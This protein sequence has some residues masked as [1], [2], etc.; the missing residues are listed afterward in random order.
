MS[1]CRCF[2][3]SQTVF[4]AFQASE[5]EVKWVIRGSV[6]VAG[7]GGTLLTN[8]TDNI[9]LFWVLGADLSYT[10]M[11]PQLFCVLFTNV[12]NGYGAVT[13]YLVA[14][15]LRMLC[16]EPVLGLPVILH[17]PGC[18]LED[19]VY[20]QRFPFKTTCMLAALVSILIA[21]SVA[22]L[23]FNKGI[24]PERWDVF[25]VKSPAGGASEENDTCPSEPMLETRC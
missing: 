4:S 14:V 2:Q 6:I 8:F 18:T 11:L 15:V 17:F 12:S 25:K 24:L 9:M 13:G 22:S 7:L 10:V 19:G 20:V 21:S 23:L 5:T 3:C 1:F 16:G